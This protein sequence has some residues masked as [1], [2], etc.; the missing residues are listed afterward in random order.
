MVA[1][2]AE[3]M[4]EIGYRRAFVMHGLSADGTRGM[5]ELSTL[6]E[7][8]AAEL[9]D[10]GEISMV[11]INAQDMGIEKR[12]ESSIL[13]YADRKTEA[14]RLIRILSGIEVGGRKDIVCLNAA[15]I[16]Y[17]S[18]HASDLSEGL[19]KAAELI[20]SGKPIRKLKDWV[21]EQNANPT[22]KLEQLNK[23]LDLAYADS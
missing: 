9:N 13:H 14:I 11:T 23:M 10:D 2:I 12:D 7:T 19:E 6:G 8:V 15:P 20:D 21:S 16:L 22:E 1:P 18:G 3:A 4:R 17:I 5:D